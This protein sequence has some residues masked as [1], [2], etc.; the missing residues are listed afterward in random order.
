MINKSTIKAYACINKNT[1]IRQKSSSGGCYFA[2]AKD[3]IEQGGIVYSARFNDGFSVEHAKCS[4]VNELAQFMGSKYAPSRLG[5]TFKEIKEVL[6][7][8]K[9]VMFVGTPCQNAGLS[10]FLKKD[11]P[12]LLKVDFICHGMPDEKVWDRYSDYLKEKGEIKNIYFRN[13]DKGWYDY[14]FKVEYVD[15][16]VFEENHSDN[17]YMRG[18]LADLFLKKA[19]YECKNRG[20]NRVS[21]ITLADYWGIDDAIPEMFDNQGT[22]AVFVNTLKGEKIFNKIS[23]Q[24]S[25]RQVNLEEITKYNPSYFYNANMH[26][27]HNQF[28]EKLDNC[29]DVIKLIEN[30][31]KDKF[32]VRTLRKAKRTIKTLFHIS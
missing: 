23:E 19:C 31:L 30:C 22:S 4:S 5:N 17:I 3:F 10:S 8:G 27:N 9:R 18:F 21:D 15:G 12:T 1:S 28:M 16:T 6:E 26:K 20:F 2:L 32:I 13:K 14:N 24:F 25:I 7:K 29:K 11:Y